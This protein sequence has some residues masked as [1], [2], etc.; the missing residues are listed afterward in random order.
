MHIATNTHI[1]VPEF[2]YLEPTTVGEATSLLAQY[3]ENARLMAG[4]TDLLVQMKM[5]RR[6]PEYLIALNKIPSLNKISQI[7]GV[8]IGATASIHSLYQSPLIRENY[9]ALAEGCNW[10]STIQIMVMGTIGGNLCNASPASDT[11][12]CLL[13]FDAQVKLAS[14]S[15]ERVVALEEYFVAPGKTILRADEMLVSILLSPAPLPPGSAFIKITRVVADISKV[16]AAVKIE[17]DGNIVRDCRIALGSVAPTPVRARR[18]E[19]ALIGETFTT[20]LAERASQI[21]AQEIKPISDVRSTREY[22]QQ[23]A[24]VIV[25]DALMKAWERA[26]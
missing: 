3:G 17:R 18:A 2:D 4:G 11:A 6:Q 12:P 16:C 24:A 22:R 20:E 19:F 25:R 10:F 15:G 26:Q 9:T 8:E 21:A 23:V 14:A 5:E 7:G 13:V 1:L